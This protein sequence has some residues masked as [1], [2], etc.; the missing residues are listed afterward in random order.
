M[1]QPKEIVNLYV[2]TD[3]GVLY[4]D[5]GV[6]DLLSVGFVISSGIVIDGSLVHVSL[7]G[8]SADDHPQYILVDGTRDFATNIATLAVSP[9]A[10]GHLT[11]KDYVDTEISNA[12]SSSVA[13]VG[14]INTL[15]GTITIEGA[16]EAFVTTAG[17][18]ITIS[19]TPHPVGGE[20]TSN[21]LVGADGITVISGVETD[22]ISGFR[23]EFVAATGTLQSE[24]DLH[25]RI[26]GSRDSTGEQ[27]FGDGILATSGTFAPIGDSD[28]MLILARQ[29]T[30]IK[31]ANE[32]ADFYMFDRFLLLNIVQDEIGSNGLP[33]GGFQ[34]NLGGDDAVRSS[35]FV[36][37]DDAT[38]GTPD[39][40]KI[41]FIVRDGKVGIGPS[42]TP[43]AELHVVGSGIFDE[44][45][46]GTDFFADNLTST[47]TV[48]SPTGI[49]SESLTIS[50]S[51]VSTGTGT[52]IV[53]DTAIAGADGITV[54]SGVPTAGQVTV[55]GFL[56]QLT[57]TVTG[58]P[59]SSVVGIATLSEP[60]GHDHTTL[61]GNID[62]IQSAGHT[63]GGVIS[64]GTADNTIDVTT[65]EGYI[66]KDDDH[67]SRLMAF[68][69]PAVVGLALTT[70]AINYVGV[71]YNNGNPQIVV[72][73]TYDWNLHQEFPLGNVVSVSGILHFE[74]APQEVEDATGL[75]LERFFRTQPKQRDELDGG[76]ILSESA[77]DN[78]NI[79]VTAGAVWDRLNKFTIPA[80][81][82]SGS[83]TFDAFYFDGGAWI[84]DFG[85]TTW[86]NTQ[87]NDITSGLITMTNNRYAVLWFYLDVE[88]NIDMV[89][90]TAQY[91]S[92][93]GAE[94]EAEPSVSDVISAQGFLIGRLIFQKS[95]TIAALVETV[96]ETSFAGSL[97]TD[98]GNLTGLGDDDHTQYSLVDGTRAFSNTVAGV[99][100]VA[101]ADLTTKLYVVSVSGHLQSEIDAVD[102]QEAYN[103]GDGIIIATDGKP[104]EVQGG[105][106]TQSGIFAP[107]VANDLA[108]LISRSQTD[109]HIAN[110]HAAF[111]MFDRRLFLDIVQDEIGENGLPGGGF[112]VDLGG[113][114]GVFDSFILSAGHPLSDAI[115]ADNIR[116]IVR[117]DGKTA[118]GRTTG[119]TARLDITASGTAETAI[120]IDHLDATGD[121]KVIDIEAAPN[122]TNNNMIVWQFGS[123]ATDEG[124]AI[125]AYR[126]STSSTAFRLFTTQNESR[127]QTMKIGGP[128]NFV[129]I[130]TD[131]PTER[132]HVVGS[133]IFDGD[134]E[135]TGPTINLANLPTASAG[136]SSG[137]LWLDVSD[138]YAL[139]VTP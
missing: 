70:T 13:G 31:I 86:P 33:A 48:T 137:D 7:T 16:G 88:G 129:G 59:G 20:S 43:L 96:Y 130:N 69:H 35:F 30:P 57:T 40:D 75:V 49:F 8:L 91:T 60:A 120:K 21:A 44:T 12:I 125:S 42:D 83:D 105:F 78:Q 46:S 116:F 136:L 71:E 23:D 22:T 63:A 112:Q 47:G 94:D 19:G 5:A 119:P 126:S 135:V 134:L 131:S 28:R 101:D 102:L 118:I 24:S 124:P 54:I 122:N 39:P 52:T 36:T 1:V 27:T 85:R 139:R 14:S 15:S 117:G 74:N 2:D 113:G 25:L 132:L 41:K 109:A 50:G 58:T 81:D 65:G 45:V 56:T 26:D 114:D 111:Y 127:I 9:T 73:T 4:A 128:D 6:S 10:I 29:N 72:R 90:G 133:G 121:W 103:N 77:D 38:G 99:T 3:T 106:L 108:L 67:E 100:P 68:E 123:I 51:P 98:H 64:S 110:E 92:E 11:R 87:Y 79:L 89:Y 107:E 53:G 32:H 115:T 76:L 138:T 66:R 93:A 80:H 82:T 55:S 34:L 37:A 17:Q 95:A 18:T 97:A 62:I 84:T 61:Q 104:L